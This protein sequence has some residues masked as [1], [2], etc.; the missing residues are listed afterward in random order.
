MQYYNMNANY[1]FET[2]RD[3]NRC[4]SV[5]TCD[6]VYL[7]FFSNYFILFILLIFLE[8]IFL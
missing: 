1:C 3:I 7:K 6:L 2:V 4:F 5:L 8:N